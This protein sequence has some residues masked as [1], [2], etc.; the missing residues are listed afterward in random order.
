[1]IILKAVKGDT[2]CISVKQSLFMQIMTRIFQDRMQLIWFIFRL[3]IS[4]DFLKSM[5]ALTL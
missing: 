3:P 5:Q 2:S 1:M 4:A